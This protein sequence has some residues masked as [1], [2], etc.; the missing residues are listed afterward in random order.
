MIFA[1]FIFPYLFNELTK[2]NIEDLSSSD[3]NLLKRILELPDSTPDISL[4]LEL[5]IEPIRFLIKA[6]RIIFLH[7][8][9]NRPDEEMMLKVLKAQTNKPVKGDWFSTVC[10]D[11][12][13]FEIENT[14]E[15][16]QNMTENEVK[17]KVKIAMK[18]TAFKFLNIEKNRKSKILNLKYSELKIQNYF[19]TNKFKSKRKII[20]F[21]ARTRM[22]NVF[23]NF[24]QKIKCPLCKIGEDDQ[25]HLLECIILKFTCPQILNNTDI[26]FTD[27]FSDN[28]DKQCEVGNLL[29][30]ALR[31]R[32]E[33][34]S[35]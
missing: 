2:T 30:I 27:I 29:E 18:I 28:L 23:H 26:K 4:Y 13:E 35:T 5:G 31:K 3:R 10:N 20:I 7:H 15:E 24:G 1:L 21:K 34:L 25:K 17:R 9:L 19:T 6:K 11:I 14:I 16:I 22:L 32:T 8:I 33:I 12:E